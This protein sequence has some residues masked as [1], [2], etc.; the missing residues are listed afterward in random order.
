MTGTPDEGMRYLSRADVQRAAAEV[1]PVE[2][3]RRA[4]VLHAEGRTT[5]PPEAALRWRTPDG[6]SA[7]SLALPGAVWGKRPALGLKMINSSLGNPVRGLDR[8]QGL[9]FLF[10]QDT[11]RPVVIMEAAHLSALRTAAYTALS[12]RTLAATRDVE[13][14][15]VIG[16]GALARAHVRLLADELPGTSFA[17]YDADSS[18]Q[19]AFASSLRREGHVCAE[20][21]SAKEAVA[22]AAVV[23][24]VTITTEG[25]LPLDWLVPG[26]LV[27]HV[28]LDDVLPDVVEGADVVVVD[29]WELIAA[30]EHR[31]L[32]R[33]YRAGRLRGPS[34]E[35]FQGAEAADGARRVDASLADVL[36]GRHLGRTS[37]EQ[38]VLS[39]PFGMGVLDVALAAD[40]WAVA[41]AAGAGVPLST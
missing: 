2:S 16:C 39:N 8:A 35:S 14:V 7:R 30:D 40:V 34:G 15:A 4:L 6:F 36:A 13:R 37:A 5:L 28:S 19:R 9:T 23:V 26:A 27:A 31:L 21:G 1:D 33:M 18:R 3:V 32:G 20:A 24:T 22:G 10:D 17:V 12:V 38:I 41:R 11:A 29:D 25:Y